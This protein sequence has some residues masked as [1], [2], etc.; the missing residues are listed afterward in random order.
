MVLSFK[1]FGKRHL[2]L[3]ELGQLSGIKVIMFAFKHLASMVT[4]FSSIQLN[5]LFGTK[6][7]TSLGRFRISHA[8]EKK[9]IC[10]HLLYSV[11]CTNSL[12]PEVLKVIVVKFPSTPCFL[13]ATS[14]ALFLA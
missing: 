4:T 7:G 5:N 11:D 2:C 1:Y 14:L 10:I 6:S 12:D 13:F 8:R 3:E 9:V